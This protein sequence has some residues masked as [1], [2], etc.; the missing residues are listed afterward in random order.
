[1]FES[2]M[3]LNTMPAAFLGVL[4]LAT[5]LNLIYDRL[6]YYCLAKAFLSTTKL[7]HLVMRSV[8]F[9][10]HNVVCRD[11]ASFFGVIFLW[12]V[13]RSLFHL[14]SVLWLPFFCLW[15]LTFSCSLDIPT[16]MIFLSSVYS[17]IP[18][19]L[20]VSMYVCV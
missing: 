2:N 11:G 13:S 1:M 10:T 15:V 3:I 20:C 17:F 5:D 14:S 9:T 16:G 8:L 19:V 7:A 12:K 6:C 4:C 18:F